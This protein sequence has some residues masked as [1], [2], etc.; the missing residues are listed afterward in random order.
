[1]TFFTY[2][3]AAAGYRGFIISKIMMWIRYKKKPDKI[4]P[5]VSLIKFHFNLTFEGGHLDLAI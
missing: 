2:L 3:E 1:M 5:E 4:F